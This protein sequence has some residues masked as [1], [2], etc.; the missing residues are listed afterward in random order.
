MRHL[1]AYVAGIPELKG[2]EFGSDKVND[3]FAAAYLE[4]ANL[5]NIFPSVS[6]NGSHFLEY[7]HRLPFHLV[8]NLHVNGDISL[9]CINFQGVAA[10]VGS[11]FAQP[12]F[13]Q[14]S[15]SGYS[16]VT[17]SNPAVPFHG[18]IPGAFIQF[19]KITIVGNVPFFAN[20]FHVNLKNTMT[21]NIALHINPRFKEGA[22][23]RNTLINGTW[24]SEERY[25]HSMPFSPGQAFHMEITN[26]KKNYKVIV[27]GQVVFDYTHRIPP[28][29]VDQLEIAGDVNLSSVQY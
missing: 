9:N 8:Q 16:G 26:L 29:H 25:I 20:R 7:K 6:I 2:Q 21:G 23:V 11:M 14:P 17:L 10:S 24:G 27:N 1:Q 28:S 13:A 18:A 12:G 3:G 4:S 19:R 22:L 15:F 5:N